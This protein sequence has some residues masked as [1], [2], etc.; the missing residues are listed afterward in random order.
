MLGNGGSIGGHFDSLLDRQLLSL[1]ES[2]MNS[3]KCLLMTVDL[4]D[5]SYEVI[6]P[7]EPV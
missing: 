2:V 3:L 4:L 7:N 5:G 1:N 6:C